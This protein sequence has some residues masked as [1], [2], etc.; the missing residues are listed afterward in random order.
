MGRLP[1]L[2]SHEYHSFSLVRGWGMVFLGYRLLSCRPLPTPFLSF[3][4]GDRGV[5]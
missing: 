3:G 5:T 1:L 4:G 2:V